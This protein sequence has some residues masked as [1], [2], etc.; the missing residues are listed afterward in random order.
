MN[1]TD[2]VIV[3]A[4]AAGLGI[5]SILNETNVNYVVLDKGNVGNSFN[6]WPKSMEMITPSFPSN[7]FGQMDLNSICKA[8]S[9]AYSFQKEHLNGKEYAKYLQTVVNY[10]DLIVETNTDN[11]QLR[12]SNQYRFS[13]YS[14]HK[15]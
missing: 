1:V 9:P 4:G 10:F 12:A 11:C 5:A 3:G 7:A 6:K 2:I 14:T 8:T 13:V 15:P